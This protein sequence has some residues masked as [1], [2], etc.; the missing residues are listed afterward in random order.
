[1]SE[2]RLDGKVAI[3]N[4]ATGGWGS[5][6]AMVL[7]RRGASVVL[8]A[9]TQSKLDALARRI[10]QRGGTAIGVAQD[11]RTLEGAERLI[12]RAVSEYGRVDVLMHAAGVRAVDAAAKN[13][14]TASELTSLYGGTLLEMSPES[15]DFVLA[16][17]LTSVFS[18]AKAA[19]AQMV[20]QGEGGAIVAVVG[21]ILGAAGQSV[22]AA[23]KAGLLNA[24]WSWSDELKPHGVTVNGVRGYVRSLLTD[25]GFD[26]EAYD[27]DAPRTG[28]ELPTEPAEAG[29]LIAWLA[30]AEA[31]DITGAYIGLDGAPRDVLG[32]QAPRCRSLQSP[33]LDGRGTQSEFRS[34][35]PSSS[36]SSEHDPGRPRPLLRARSRSRRRGNATGVTDSYDE[37]NASGAP[38][39]PPRLGAREFGQRRSECAPDGAGHGGHPGNAS[40]ADHLDTDAVGAGVEVILDPSGDGLL[41]AP[42]DQAVDEP[43]GAAVRQVVLGE[44]DPAKVVGVVRQGQIVVQEVAADSPGFASVSG[45]RHGLLGEELPGRPEDVACHRGVLRGHVVRVGTSGPAARELEHLGSKGGQDPGLGIHR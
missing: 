33:R 22:H 9:R 15:W 36:S 24:L 14:E 28:P 26:V 18:C 44:A 45:Q 3:V 5:G 32:A 16:A 1:M 35:H 42:G 23:A 41:V 12:E 40:L 8:N 38:E 39:R 6:T 29:E 20:D 25:P 11:V 2:I 21:T 10:R 37:P 43:V 27:F 13:K 31:T 34:D 4:G 30:S 17:E 7:A 19:A